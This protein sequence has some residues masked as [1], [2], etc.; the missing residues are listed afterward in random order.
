MPDNPTATNVMPEA[1]SA[2]GFLTA[3]MS[4]RQNQVIHRYFPETGMLRREL[5]PKHIAFFD[6]GQTHRERLMIAANRIG[7]TDAGSYE[8]TCHLTGE[9]PSWWKG[10]RFTEPVSIWVA[11]DTGST[12]RDITQRKLLGRAGSPGSG[13]IPDQSIHHTTS[14][15]GMADAIDMAW[16]SHV[17]GGLSILQFKSYD[18]RRESFQGTAQHIIWLDEEPPVDVYQEC[19][20]RTMKTEDF[21]GGK[22]LMTFTPLQGLTDL[23]LDF[24]PGGRVPDQK[25]KA[26]RFVVMADWDDAPHLSENEKAE[27][28]ESIHPHQRSART[29]GVP[30][31]GS[32][33]IFPIE[34]DQLMVDDFELPD[35][36][37]R[38]YGFDVGWKFTAAVWGAF[39]RETGVLYLYSVYKR[40]EAEPPSH[41]A[42]IKARGAW[43]RGRI[44]PASRGRSQRDGKMLMHQ[45]QVLGLDVKI[46][47][48][49][50]ES[51]LLSVWRMMT[52]GKLKVFKSCKPWF[53][54]LRLYRRNEKGQ[55]VKK[56]DHLMDASRYL[57]LPGTNWLS[58]EPTPEEKP[59]PVTRGASDG[60]LDWMGT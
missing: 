41:A 23:V 40:G 52:T 4:R 20:L 8:V 57:I 36:W 53:E 24:L 2:L 49:A 26:S 13:F 14:K 29:K 58:V 21:P 37:P 5:Y 9:Y 16:I 46:A 51:G 15:R 43:V 59:K 30:A 48:N 19:L 18:Q 47:P 35:H 32:G 11:G 55:I 38:G 10:C 39:D 12:V 28:L 56:N 34:E 22:V 7:K 44:D 45:Y 6:A 60:N 27:L 33:A 54:E 50:V 17:S 1:S 42:A 31:L 3:E 25:T